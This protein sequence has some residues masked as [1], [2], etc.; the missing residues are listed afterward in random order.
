M[1][2]YYYCWSIFAAGN[3]REATSKLNAPKTVRWPAPR[4]CPIFS[5]LV[6]TV[7]ANYISSLTV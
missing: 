5:A 7:Q 4:P 3:S 2:M 1:S 6:K